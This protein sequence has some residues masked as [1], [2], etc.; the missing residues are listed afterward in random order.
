[1]TDLAFNIPCQA[2]DPDDFLASNTVPKGPDK[3]ESFD[4]VITS[5]PA[6]QAWPH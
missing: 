3:T 2:Y 1:M 6:L 5:T 4:H